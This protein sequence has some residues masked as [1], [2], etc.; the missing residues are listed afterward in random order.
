MMGVLSGLHP[1]SH[2]CSMISY[3]YFIGDICTPFVL[4]AISSTPNPQ[5]INEC[6][7]VKIRSLLAKLAN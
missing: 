4:L 6:V 7:L 5:S 3:V 1:K 2:A